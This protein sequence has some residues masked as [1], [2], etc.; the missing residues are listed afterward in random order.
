MSA[1]ADALHLLGLVAAQEENYR[2]AVECMDKAIAIDSANPGYSNRGLALQA[3]GNLDAAGQQDVCLAHFKGR[4]S[5]AVMLEAMT[6]L[7]SGAAAK[8]R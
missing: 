3:Q 2:L 8:P 7:E 5:K 6:M 4:D 1:H